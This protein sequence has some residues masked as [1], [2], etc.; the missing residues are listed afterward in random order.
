[1]SNYNNKVLVTG[2]GGFIGS[3][4]VEGLVEAGHQVRA[5][6]HYNF[7][8]SW[9][10]LDT[11]PKELMAN[12]EVVSGDIRDPFFVRKAVSGCETVF[13]L[14]ALI[15]IPYSYIAPATYVETNIQGTLN[16]LQACRDEDISRLVHTSTSEVYGTA[17]YVP[18]DEKH[19]I[20][21]QSPYSATKIGADKLAE[22]YFLSFELPVAT[23]RPFNTF[24][25][26][27]SARAVIPTLITQVLSGTEVISLGSLN[28]I[29]DF[30]YVKDT[31]RGFMAVAASDQTVGRV[32][33]IGRGHGISISELAA[34]ILELC[35]ST[36][37]IE[38]DLDRVRPETSEVFE[39][40]CDSSEARRL[41][42]WEPQYSIRDGLEATI[43][44]LRNNLHRYKVDRYNV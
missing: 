23:I 25:P 21:G 5:M 15:A 31:V 39:L 38:L 17:Q 33:N 36:A 30:N 24:G 26:R 32:T 29:R 37:T 2:A 44:W 42:G 4:L 19:P 1:M 27:Q 43:T 7:Q 35:G 41:F 9:G 16:V 3:H 22:S 11:F 28:P 6:V 20:V 18:I 12:V 14:A 13:H 8:N 40:V 34:L 10:W